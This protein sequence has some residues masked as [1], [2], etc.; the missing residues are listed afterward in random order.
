MG[1]RK[2]A[3]KLTDEWC[4]KFYVECKAEPPEKK[5]RVPKRITLTVRA[6]GEV[7]R[8]RLATDVVAV[9]GLK[10][11]V[12]QNGS[13][14]YIY[15]ENSPDAKGSAAAIVQEGADGPRFL[16]TAGHVA[17]RIL[18]STGASPGERILDD[19]GNAI[20]AL[21]FAPDIVKAS[22]D[23]A[24]ISPSAAAPYPDL[25]RRANGQPVTDICPLQ[26]FRPSAGADYKMFSWI[27]ERVMCF[28]GY[29]VDVQQ[30]Y[31]VGTVTFPLLLHFDCSAT[32]GDSGALVVDA[33]NRAVGM[34]IL[35]IAGSDSFC[36]PTE[37]VLNGCAQTTALRIV[38]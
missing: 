37:T 13:V 15:N 14:S 20:G 23:A 11:I 36:L 35:G 33:Q 2:Q 18:T 17:A 7:H 3:G 4:V 22:V 25:L 34:H 26:G 31:A 8:I 10:P 5:R 38:N 1:R 27:A 16:L 28:H 9:G 29:S 30:D 32:G 6:Q 19:G 12:A 24:L 21:S